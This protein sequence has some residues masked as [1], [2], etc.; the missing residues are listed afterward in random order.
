MKGAGCGPQPEAAARVEVMLASRC[1]DDHGS[2]RE[3]FGHSNWKLYEAFNCIEAL[4]LL[5]QFH[6]PVVI[7]NCGLPEGGWKT[8]LPAVE[9]LPWRPR[10]IVC[11]RLADEQ[12]W[13]EVLNLGGYDVLS[14]PFDADEVFR[15][16]YLAW[17]SARH[18]ARRMAAASQTSGPAYATG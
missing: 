5:H 3:I 17:H 4:A 10:L 1:E 7:C 2:L 15:V 18:E 14:T 16:S 13:G 8:L 6:L 12:L 11:S 9:A